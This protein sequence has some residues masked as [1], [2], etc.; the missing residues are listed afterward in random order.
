MSQYGFFAKFRTISG[1]GEEL[2]SLLVQ[3]AKA[4]APLKACRQYIV[5]RHAKDENLVCVHEIW[6]TKEDHDDSL[7][8]EGCKELIS[9]AMPLLTGRPEGIP[10]E[11]MGGKGLAEA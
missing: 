5:Y 8:I 11:V 1:K 9:Q 2:V 7:K 4:V 6:D 3:A 10:L